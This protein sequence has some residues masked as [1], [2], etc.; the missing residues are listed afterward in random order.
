M[1]IHQ[2]RDDGNV[3]NEIEQQFHAL[4]TED[5]ATEERNAG[6]I[7]ARP[8]EVSNE[9]LSHRIFACREH[10][11]DRRRGRPCRLRRVAIAHDHGHFAADQIGRERRQAVKL[12]VRMPVLDR[13]ILAHDEA[14]FVQTLA[15]RR[16]EMHER[17]G[18]CAPEEPDHRHRRLLRARRKRPHRGAAKQRDELAPS[19]AV[20]PLW[21]T[22]SVCRCCSF[23][24]AD[25][26]TAEPVWQPAWSSVVGRS[27]G[28]T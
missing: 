5:A 2:H 24:L 17:R 11:R 22:D 28:R 14:G 21:R 19:H 18:R 27:L 12:I 6:E 13:H 9:A 26:L 10:D 25:E 15:E 3:G 16:V 1:W 7:A 20:P 8:A 4:C 23:S